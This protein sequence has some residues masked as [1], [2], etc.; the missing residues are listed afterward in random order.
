MFCPLCGAESEQGSV[1]YIGFVWWSTRRSP[2]F[3]W[4]QEAL[5]FPW[6]LDL[7]TFLARPWQVPGWRCGPCDAVIA[8]PHAAACAH[9]FE[10]G[11]V[12]PVG[13]LWWVGGPAPWR[14]H[15]VF[16]F[17]LKGRDGRAAVAVARSRFTVS[18]AATR[19]PATRCARC[20]LLVVPFV[21]DHEH[22]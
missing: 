16:P 14:P 21:R 22:A 4:H 13:G 10:R 1:L 7:K 17:S 8:T 18:K 5:P 20:G 15:L 12:F 2:G 6:L 3:L 19:V 9:E 11:W